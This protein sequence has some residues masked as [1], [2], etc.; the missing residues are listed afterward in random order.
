MMK[1]HKMWIGKAMIL[2]NDNLICTMHVVGIISAVILS[3]DV[4]TMFLRSWKLVFLLTSV[5]IVFFGN[6]N[7]Q[8]CTV[9]Q[10]TCI[11]SFLN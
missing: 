8:R 3:S 9:E 2:L 6:S 4:L 5:Y 11:Y 7:Y 1:S 10:R